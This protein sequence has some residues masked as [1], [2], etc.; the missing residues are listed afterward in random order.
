MFMGVSHPNSSYLCPAS[1]RTLISENT[2]GSTWVTFVPNIGEEDYVD[3]DFYTRYFPEDVYPWQVAI[4][5]VKNAKWKNMGLFN[6]DGQCAYR[7]YFFDFA[8]IETNGVYLPRDSLIVWFP[9]HIAPATF[10][11]DWLL[12]PYVDPDSN[13]LRVLSTDLN[14]VR[15]RS[16]LEPIEAIAAN[17]RMVRAR[18][19]LEEEENEE[20]E[21]ASERES[22]DDE[23][24]DDATFEQLAD[25]AIAEFEAQQQ[26]NVVDEETDDEEVTDV[27]PD[28]AVVEY[29]T[30]RQAVIDIEDSDDEI[31]N[32]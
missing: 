26:A 31:V 25:Q 19:M 9:Y 22:D 21:T 1:S 17:R 4:Y 20:E 18:E 3:S 11:I 29:E 15:P 30:Q 13:S 16:E 24:D 14:R 6:E 8:W 2:R 7:Y 27:S 28:A 5:D 23:D 12:S 32:F 10:D